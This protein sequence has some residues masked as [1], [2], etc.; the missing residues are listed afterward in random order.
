[1]NSQNNEI[2]PLTSLEQEE[3]PQENSIASSINPDPI[4]VVELVS[5]IGKGV[6]DLASSVLDSI[7]IDF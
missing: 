3:K 4:D 2:A 6:L 5:E 1:M 7:D